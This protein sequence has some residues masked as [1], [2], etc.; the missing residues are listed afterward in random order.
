MSGSLEKDY[1]LLGIKDDSYDRLYKKLK[2]IPRSVKNF[3]LKFENSVEGK[4]VRL[5]SRE[6]PSYDANGNVQS[7]I[8]FVKVEDFH[9]EDFDEFLANISEEDKV[10]LSRNNMPQ[11]VWFEKYGAERGLVEW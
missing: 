11:K 6:H 1:K 4:A 3:Y 9:I 10:I 5:H 7:E 8:C 2:E